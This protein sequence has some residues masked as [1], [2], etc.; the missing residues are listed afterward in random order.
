MILVYNIFIALYSIVLR[1]SSLWNVKAKKWLEGRQSLFADLEKNISASDSV[2]WIHSASAGEFE[3]AKPIIESL[4]KAYPQHK[5][6]ASVFSPSG[7]SAAQKYKGADYVFYLPLDTPANAK[8]LIKLLRPQLVIFI[9]YDYWYYHLHEIHENKIPLLL[10]SSIFR[11]HQTFFKWYGR[12]YRRMLHFFTH[13]FVQDE[14]S[15]QHLQQINVHQATIGGDTRFDRVVKIANGFE[16]IN[17]I[18]EFIKDS[19]VFI[20]GSTWPDD[21][22][23]IRKLADDSASMK[24]IIAPHEIN[25]NHLQQLQKDFPEAIFYSQS[26]TVTNLGNYKILIIDNIGML[27]KLY[28]YATLTYIGGGFT[29]DGIHNSLEAAV[30]G[31]PVLFGPNYKK[32][33]EAIELIESGGAFSFAASEELASLTRRLLNDKSAYEKACLASK[34]YV[35]KETGATQKVLD[36]IQENRLLTN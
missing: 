32:Y 23:V 2:I 31:K 3:Q 11:P 19:N 36:Y 35:T 7:Y 26:G 21:E 27:S 20:A 33:R 13:I 28:K 22:H 25:S 6:A 16:E 10:V 18:A 12:F 29:K 17:H 8:K 5:I 4:K 1:I 30:F 24:F 14:K 34:N 9:K 15:L